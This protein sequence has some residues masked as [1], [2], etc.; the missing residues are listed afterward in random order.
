MAPPWDIFL[1]LSAKQGLW[2][3]FNELLHQNLCLQWQCHVVCQNFPKSM[4]HQHDDVMLMLALYELPYHPTDVH[5]KLGYMSTY[6][7]SGHV[8]CDTATLEFYTVYSLFWHHHCKY[9]SVSILSRGIYMNDTWHIFTSPHG[10]LKV[11]KMHN[12]WQAVVLP[13]Q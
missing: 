1:D 13:R 3:T 2:T 5:D 7:V 12:M 6:P 4:P 11:P 9:M 10:P 8:R